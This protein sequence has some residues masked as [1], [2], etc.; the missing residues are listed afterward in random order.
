[1]HLKEGPK[2]IL[3]A[4]TLFQPWKKILKSN[5]EQQESYFLNKNEQIFIESF[6]YSG[7]SQVPSSLFPSMSYE[8]VFDKLCIFRVHAF[9]ST[10]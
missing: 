8:V 9:L 1:M 7:I 6:I 10:A 2:L 3:Y 5:S 4:C